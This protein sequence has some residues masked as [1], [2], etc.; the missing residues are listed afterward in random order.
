[1]ALTHGADTDELRAV[2]ARL[3]AQAGKVDGAQ[4]DLKGT[5]ARLKESWSGP[6]ARAYLANKQ[7]FSDLESCSTGLRRYAKELVAQADGQDKVSDTLDDSGGTS[8]PTTPTTP[9][10]PTTPP[11]SDGSSLADELHESGLEPDR[12]GGTEW[13]AG[14]VTIGDDG[15]SVEVWNAEGEAG[16]LSAERSVTVSGDIDHGDDGMS[17]FTGQ[18][19]VTGT[20]TLDVPGSKFTPGLEQEGHVTGYVAY[21]VE[22]PTDSLGNHPIDAYTP[23]DPAALPPG[24]TLTMEAGLER[25]HDG[26]VH[27]K[28]LLAESSYSESDFGRATV[29]RVDDTSVRV[30]V[31]DGSTLALANALGLGTPD[32]GVTAGHSSAMEFGDMQTFTLDISTPEGLEAYHQWLTTGTIPGEGADFVSDQATV[33]TYDY[34]SG[35]TFGIEAGPFGMSSDT[36]GMHGYET[37]VTHGDGSQQQIFTQQWADAGTLTYTEDAASGGVTGESG[38]YTYA[39]EGLSEESA[40]SISNL[41]GVDV[42]PGSSIRVDVTSTQMQALLHHQ[43][44][45][46][47]QAVNSPTYNIHGDASYLAAGMLSSGQGDPLYVL[48]LLAQAQPDPGVGVLPGVGEI[49]H[50]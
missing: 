50:G 7:I 5:W 16:I 31:G 8:T 2:A 41:Y 23:F 9:T 17:T 30:T 25:G 10:N 22:T 19:D 24:T 39:F 33:Q 14:P 27:W 29:E 36:T 47:A 6:D 11:T 21:E 26:T 3:R 1:M 44:Q 18:V 42:E 35:S 28:G 48:S 13:T 4:S 43:H 15:V 40:Q 49:H 12:T 32:F 34:T 46:E 20:G 45:L 38:T 37:V